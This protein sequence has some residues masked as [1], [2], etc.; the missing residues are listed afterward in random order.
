MNAL[1]ETRPISLLNLSEEELHESLAH[2]CGAHVPRFRAT[3]ICEWIYRHRVTRFEEMANVPADLRK[4]LV[5]RYVIVQSEIVTE[6]RSTDGTN[7]V[8]LRWRS[9]GTT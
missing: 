3:Q 8:L 4:T 7:K 1:D 6:Q 9:G 5:R 2:E